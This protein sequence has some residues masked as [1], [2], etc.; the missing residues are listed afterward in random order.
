MAT[1]NKHPDTL[2]FVPFINYVAQAQS[3][4]FSFNNGALYNVDGKASTDFLIEP[5][6]KALIYHDTQVYNALERGQFGYVERLI[7]SNNPFIESIIDMGLHDAVQNR[8]RRH[9][10]AL[11]LERRYNE[12]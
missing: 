3:L 5:F 8:I 9:R 4:L 10:I 2:S 7:E 1:I 6:A 12:M 11:G